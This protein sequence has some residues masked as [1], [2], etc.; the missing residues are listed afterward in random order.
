M[1]FNWNGFTRGRYNEM[2]SE[3]HQDWTYG[4]IICGDLCFDVVIRYYGYDEPTIT[5]DCYVA[6]EDTGYGYRDGMAYDYADG[7]YVDGTDM[8]YTQFQVRAE[9]AIRNYVENNDKVFG[10]SLVEKANETWS[11]WEEVFK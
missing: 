10:Y 8:S 6:N 3:W 2:V 7:T 1:K 5:L 4:N 9:N 11:T